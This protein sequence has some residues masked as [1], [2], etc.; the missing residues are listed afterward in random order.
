MK[1]V[2]RM[3][4]Q[5]LATATAAM[6]KA[7]IRPARRPGVLTEIANSHSAAARTIVRH[8]RP[9]SNRR[10]KAML[11][12]APVERSAAEAEL[13]RGKRD[14]EVMHSERPLDHLLLKLVEIEARP[15]YRN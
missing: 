7:T 2:R 3:K 12:H 6:R 11:F 13:G 4:F 5:R 9:N 10:L 8:A 14:V 15:D 1:L